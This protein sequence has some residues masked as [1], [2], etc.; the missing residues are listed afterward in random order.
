MRT[1][2]ISLLRVRKM[3]NKLL[4]EYLGEFNEDSDVSIIIANPKDRKMYK[5]EIM[6]MIAPEDEE[7]KEGPVICIEVGQPRDMDKEEPE[8]AMDVEREAQPELPRL[9]NNNQRKEFLKT[10]RDWLV[11]FEV[12]QAEEIYYR[13]ILPDESAIVICEYKQYVAWK[14]RYTDENPESTYTKSYLLEPGY[15]HLHDC[16][17]NETSLVKK[18]MEVQKK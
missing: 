14:E 8:M 13:Y 9:K 6:F 15:H 2:K 1:E 18:L 16:E 4:K 17:T 12:P 5:P 11:W 7:E 10:Y 3:E